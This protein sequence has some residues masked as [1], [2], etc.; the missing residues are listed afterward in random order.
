[1]KSKPKKLRPAQIAQIGS[2]TIF[3]ED[4]KYLEPIPKVRTL[5]PQAPKIWGYS[6]TVYGQRK[7][8]PQEKQV[9]LNSNQHSRKELR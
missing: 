6:K 2:E 7:F 4:E 8:I 5:P 3:S 9:S 1:V